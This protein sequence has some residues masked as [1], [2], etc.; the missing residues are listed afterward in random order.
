MPLKSVLLIILNLFHALL[1]LLCLQREKDQLEARSMMQ[2]DDNTPVVFDL[3]LSFA[4]LILCHE[5]QETR[6]MENLRKT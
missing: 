4:L 6:E 3:S 2:R 1:S 5:G